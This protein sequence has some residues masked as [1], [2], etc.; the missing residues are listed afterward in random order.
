[1]VKL[2]DQGGVVPKIEI[3]PGKTPDETIMVVWK[4]EDVIITYL[5]NTKVRKRYDELTSRLRNE[6]RKVLEGV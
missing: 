6:L 5:P 2:F 3:V 4:G 1:M